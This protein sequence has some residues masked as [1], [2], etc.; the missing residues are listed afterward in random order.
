M[1]ISI[2]MFLHIYIDLFMVITSETNHMV[3]KKLP[4]PILSTI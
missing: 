2:Y 3:Q 4:N 1:D